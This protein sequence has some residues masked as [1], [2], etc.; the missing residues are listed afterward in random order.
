MKLISVNDLFLDYAY[1]I[2]FMASLLVLAMI[3][4]SSK[5]SFDDDE[6]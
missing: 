3:A 1:W 5:V 4:Y 6:S 2:A